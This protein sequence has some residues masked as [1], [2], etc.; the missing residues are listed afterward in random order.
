MHSANTINICVGHIPFPAQFTQYVDLMLTP[1]PLQTGAK[2]IHVPDDTFGPNGDT[3]SEYA[4]LFWL[5]DHLDDIAAGYQYLRVFHYR[6]FIV[7][8]LPAPAA[9][10]S[11]QNWAKVIQAHEL[12]QF[13]SAFHRVCQSELFNTQVH[14]EHGVLVQYAKAHVLE[15]MLNFARF[16][17]NREILPEQQVAAFASMRRFIPSSS[18]ATYRV[19]SFRALFTPLRRAAGFMETPCYRRHDGYQRR[20]MG[21]LLERLNS[22]LVLAFMANRLLPPAQGQNM[23]ISDVPHISFTS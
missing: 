3:L 7:P 21:F 10:A 13:E 22:Y 14:L 17:S 23:V 4:Q 6:R 15:D 1:V 20:A 8:A 18:I 9:P 5:L 11:N 19:Q 2:T 12:G 16:L